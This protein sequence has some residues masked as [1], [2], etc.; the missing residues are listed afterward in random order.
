MSGQEIETAEGED[1]GTPSHQLLRA[2][3]TRVERLDGEIGDL[4]ADRSDVLKEAK[5]AGFDRK[6]MDEVL[7]RRKMEPALRDEL[8]SVVAVYEEALHGQPRGMVWGGDLTPKPAA[9]PPPRND[10]ERRALAALAAAEAA[11]MAERA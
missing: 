2:F 7:R 6:A 4:R 5:A 3:I 8:D 11:E 1:A 9:L 10:R